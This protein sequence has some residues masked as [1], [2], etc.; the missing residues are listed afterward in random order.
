MIYR[1]SFQGPVVR[2]PFLFPRRAPSAPWP[3]RALIL[4]ATQTK[5]RPLSCSSI[6]FLLGHLLFVVHN[7][8]KTPQNQASR[9]WSQGPSITQPCWKGK[10]ANGAREALGP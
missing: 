9:S 8:S 2:S 6:S 10:A 3:L 4:H 7:L 5:H 1:V